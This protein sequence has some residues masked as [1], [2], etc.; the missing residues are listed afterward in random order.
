M[1]RTCAAGLD[2]PQLD[3]SVDALS[4]GAVLAGRG[5][6]GKS[7]F[8]EHD[9]VLGLVPLSHWEREV[10]RIQALQQFLDRLGS[11]IGKGNVFPIACGVALLAETTLVG[12]SNHLDDRPLVIGC[13]TGEIPENRRE[14]VANGPLYKLIESSTGI[15]GPSHGHL[16]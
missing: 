12:E 4:W 6:A 16:S 8:V 14:K 2:E 1:P 7:P 9:V 3:P 15:R 5:E 13:A 10:R 11:L